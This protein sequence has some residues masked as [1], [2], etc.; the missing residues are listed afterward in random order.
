MRFITG[1]NVE[2]LED[3]DMIINKTMDS[4]DL[5]TLEA[6]EIINELNELILNVKNKGL[7]ISS[8]FG[9]F[10]L[11]GEKDTFEWINRGYG[12]SNLAGS[13]D[14]N[15][16]PWF[17]YWEIIWIVEHNKF[18]KNHKV[19]DLGGS[20][21]LFSY[22]L[23]SKGLEVITVDIQNNLV[24]NANFV[25]RKM[26]WNLNNYC[27][28]IRALDFD[29][30][31]DHITS[32]CVFEHIPIYDRVYINH[33]IKKLLKPGGDFSITFDYRNPSK[34]ARI[35]TP[36]DVY[37]QFIAPSGLEIRGNKEFCENGKS[38]LL[39]PF[40][41]N[42]QNRFMREYKLHEVKSGNF[43]KSLINV[44]KNGNDYTFGALFLKKFKS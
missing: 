8:W 15:N 44:I 24:E 41:Y 39:H 13:V 11:K 32:I 27:M 19:L 14:D 2:I 5:M 33:E 28:D 21:S 38:Y 43:D 22:Y 3:I 9:M 25:A 37:E 40:F 26:G 20:S 4:D 35:C 6:K 17:L 34:Q 12:Y 18:N 29:I 31:F 30:E 42:K 1:V 23:A 10:D 7:K 36:N 16:F